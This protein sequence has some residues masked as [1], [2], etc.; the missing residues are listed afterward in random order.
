[1]LRGMGY[2]AFLGLALAVT[3]CSSF[4]G[5]GGPTRMT[6][7]LDNGVVVCS[8][9]RGSD[10]YNHRRCRSANKGELFLFSGAKAWQRH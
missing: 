2:G 4:S 1:M 3:G 10:R 6:K 5:G 9:G 7:N 8:G